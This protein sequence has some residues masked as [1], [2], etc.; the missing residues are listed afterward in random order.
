MRFYPYSTLLGLALM[1]AV[2]AT[3]WFTPVFHLTLVAGVPFILVMSLVYRLGR[4]R[5]RS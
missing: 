3:T 5:H 4:S 2:M 1:L